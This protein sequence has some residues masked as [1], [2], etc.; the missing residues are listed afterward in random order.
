MAIIF[1]VYFNG[2]D[3]SNHV[4]EDGLGRITL[5][6]L[7]NHITIK[8]DH[9]SY[10]VCVNGC[11][12]ETND[13]RDLGTIFTFHLEKQVIRIAEQVE[14]LVHNSDSNVILNVYGFSRGGAA[15]FLLCQKL[16]HIPSDRLTI[17]VASFEPVPGNFI[18]GVYGDILLGINSTLS[19]AVANLTDCRNLSNMLVLFTNE[20]LPDIACHAPILP[21]YPRTCKTEVDITPG[22]H[23][24]AVFFFKKGAEVKPLNDESAIIFHRIV[25]F[26][27]K[28]GTSFNFKL[29]DLHP[30]LI[31]SNE[32]SEDTFI[33]RRLLSLYEGLTRETFSSDVGKSRSMHLRNTIFTADNPKKY[34]NRFH[35][36]ISN[37]EDINDKN[38]VLTLQEYMPQPVDSRAI[39]LTQMVFALAMFLIIYSKYFNN[40]SLESEFHPPLSL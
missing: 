27:Q 23:K 11:G 8:D 19:A 21:A 6:A 37:V 34:L 31:C 25:D 5:A 13:V 12:V 39:L 29:L 16:K 9:S 17:N 40:P 18:T 20:P 4:P 7:L 3:D 36:Q 10:S 28:C 1:S 2:T 14:Q 33:D 32:Y 24:S 38:S 35:Q 15:A 22:C 26:M 30:N